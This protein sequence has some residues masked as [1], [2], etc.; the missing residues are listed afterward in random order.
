MS[1]SNDPQGYLTELKQR[2][3]EVADLRQA[4]AVL[5][6]DQATYMPPAGN[7]GR[8]RAMATLTR[9]AH[10]KF[11]DPALG[12]LL[13]SLQPWAE[14]LPYESDEAALVRVTRRDYEKATRVPPAFAAQVTEHQASTYQV[15]TEARP[16]ND[17]GRVRD[18]L[19]RTLE[20][21]LKYAN[22]FPGYDHP[23]DPLI[24][25]ADYGM[26]ARTVRT[27]FDTLQKALTPMVAA[28]TAQAEAD[29]A[30]LHR[31]FAV[32]V[33]RGFGEAIIRDYGYDFDRG[34]QDLT[35]H[36]FATRFNTGDVRITTRFREEDLAD[37]LFSTLHESG[38]A[39]Y[40]LGIDPAFDGTPLGTGTSAGVHESQS[41][42]WENLV[43]RSRG[44]WERYYPDLQATFPGK[45]DDVTLDQFYRA[46][47]KVQRSLIRVDADEVTYNLHVIIRFG[48][49][50]DMLEGKVAI[51]DLAEEWN[52]RYEAALGVTP[53]NDRLGVLQ[54]VHW[55]AAP[56]G[57]VFQGYTL[58]N[59]MSATFINAALAAHPE[60]PAQIRQGQ[61]GTLHG[62]LQENIYQH[63]SKFTAD[64]LV[65]RITGAPLSI[66]PY[67]AYLRGKYGE[68]YQLPA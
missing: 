10:E 26:K 65:Q 27:L 4:N 18:G 15:W 2:L 43:G 37:G 55:F 41:R 38:H 54:D 5:N 49:E 13:D 35:H 50:L 6:W 29:E 45:L 24:D 53:P 33:Q 14:S 28:I 46:I 16:A 68:L 67:L 44:F 39:M 36:P 3:A 9:L 19:E 30:P 66:E 21:S 64:E 34:R 47:N 63:G 32:D 52:A 51:R 42:T 23:A 7:A 61:F 56:I 59:I 8:G 48:L 11:T 17:F 62:W 22:F 31:G 40:E 12:R 25:D 20:Y 57:G 1:S 58:G 60:I